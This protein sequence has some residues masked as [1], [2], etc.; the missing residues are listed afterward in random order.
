MKPMAYVSYAIEPTCINVVAGTSMAVFQVVTCQRSCGAIWHVR[1][2]EVI[3][4]LQTGA[5]ARFSAQAQFLDVE[6]SSEWQTAD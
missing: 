5:G 2:T 6:R 3:C 4:L 1:G